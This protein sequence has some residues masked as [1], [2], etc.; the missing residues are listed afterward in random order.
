[1]YNFLVKN[2]QLVAF[3]IGLLITII[4][5]VGAVGGDSPERFNFGLMTA[6]GLSILCAVV[7]ILFGLFQVASDPKGS[8]KGIITFAL[9]I[10]LFVVLYSTADPTLSPAMVA[11]GEGAGLTE[12]TSKFISG[13]ILTTLVLLGATGVVF[14]LSEIRNFFK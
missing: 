10:G 7:M 6:I 11:G 8:L 2:G 9:L 14:A 3:G 13:A 1:M 5:I 12:G 4:Y